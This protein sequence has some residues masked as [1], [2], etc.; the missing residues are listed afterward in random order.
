MKW[1]RFINP[2]FKNNMQSN[3][4]DLAKALLNLPSKT[5]TLNSSME[6]TGMSKISTMKKNIIALKFMIKTFKFTRFDINSEFGS[7]KFCNVKN[8]GSGKNDNNLKKKIRKLLEQRQH[9][10]E[11][12]IPPSEYYDE[13][14]NLVVEAPNYRDI[15]PRIHLNNNVNS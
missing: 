5:L 8:D 3:V 11:I 13:K 14:L 9:K 15:L 6:S 2:S 12:I 10:D 7:Q 4:H 1:L